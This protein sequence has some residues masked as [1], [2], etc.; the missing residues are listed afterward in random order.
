MHLTILPTIKGLA[1]GTVYGERV[2][3]KTCY[4][5]TQ[6]VSQQVGE[7]Y[8]KSMQPLHLVDSQQTLLFIANISHSPSK[9]DTL[10]AI[11]RSLHL[12]RVHLAVE[13]TVLQNF[14]KGEDVL[15]RHA[16]L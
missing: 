3:L 6:H 12:S 1:L 11:L 4:I 8:E 16:I 5:Y 9:R 13:K 10:G 2:T 7:R 15:R 14:I